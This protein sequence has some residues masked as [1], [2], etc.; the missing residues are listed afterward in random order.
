MAEGSLS[1]LTRKIRGEVLPAF[2][3]DSLLR[4]FPM[5]NIGGEDITKWYVNALLSQGKPILRE[6]GG[7][8]M[9]GEEKIDMTGFDV[10]LY[11]IQKRVGMNKSEFATWAKSGA[12]TVGIEEMGNQM[13]NK[14]NQALF[15]GKEAKDQISYTPTNFITDNNAT[16]D[17]P[18]DPS[19]QTTASGGVWDVFGEAQLDFANL[20]GTLEKIGGNPATSVVFYPEVASAGMRRPLINAADH[21]SQDPIISLVKKQGFLG[22]VSLKDDLLLEASGQA[23]PITSKF[24][25]YAVDLTGIE[26]GVTK[27]E[28]LESIYDPVSKKYYFDFQMIFTPAFRV[29]QYDADTYWYKKVSRITAIDLDT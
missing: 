24:D 16:S 23:T 29:K 13:A 10:K 7:D 17:D 1:R 25:I 3:R 20:A 9:A 5:R 11:D 6:A 12:L 26:I 21:Y 18:S 28:S 14:A 2:Q 27:D 8:W 22:A 19:L 15:V 4:L